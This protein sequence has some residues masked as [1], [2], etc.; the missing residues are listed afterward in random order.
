M[1][2]VLGKKEMTT[3]MINYCVQKWQLKFITHHTCA[4]IIVTTTRNLQYDLH[5]KTIV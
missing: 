2:C 3:Y 5:N 1:K 4:V